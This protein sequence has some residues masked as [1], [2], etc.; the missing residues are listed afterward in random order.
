MPV[1]AEVL[2]SLSDVL[3]GRQRMR[4][5]ASARSC[6]TRTLTAAPSVTLLRSFTMPPGNRATTA[7]PSHGALMHWR[8]VRVLRRAAV[9]AVVRVVVERG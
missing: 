4:G 9:Q 2:K 7:T 1:I 8:T 5:G 6:L 3:Q